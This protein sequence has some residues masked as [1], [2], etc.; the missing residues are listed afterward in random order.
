VNQIPRQTVL[1]RVY[2]TALSAEPLTS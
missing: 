1:E 2:I